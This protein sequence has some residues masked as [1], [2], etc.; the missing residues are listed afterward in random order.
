MGAMRS[1]W[2]G[3]A[4]PPRRQLRTAAEAWGCSLE[5]DH[6]PRCTA[7]NKRELPGDGHD[8]ESQQIARPRAAVQRPGM[9]S[10]PIE[11]ARSTR[12]ASLRDIV[13]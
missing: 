4:P 6:L 5:D 11:A 10:V 7:A 13:D 9:R 12:E 1:I 2:Y 8:T 3:Y